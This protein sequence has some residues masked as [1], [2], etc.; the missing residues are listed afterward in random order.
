M[1]LI[2][3]GSQYTCTRRVSVQ[4]TV[5]YLNVTPAPESISGTLRLYREDGYLLHED[6][7]EDYARC[8][9]SGTLLTLS[10][11]AESKASDVSPDY[12]Y[13]VVLSKGFLRESREAYISTEQAITELDLATIEAQQ[14]IT[15]LELMNLE[16]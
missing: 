9:Y 2:I 13:C 10:N 6:N 12:N 3:N 16:G 7:V 5:Q 15:E 8:E 11:A 1:Y 4:D 14:A